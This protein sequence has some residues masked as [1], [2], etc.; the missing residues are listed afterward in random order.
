MDPTKHANKTYNLVSD[1]QTF[2]E[3]TNSFSIALDKELMYVHVP[4]DSAVRAFL[5]NGLPEYLVDEI[6]D[7]HKLIDSGSTVTNTPDLS[8]F[9]QITGEQPTNLKNWLSKYSGGFQ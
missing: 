7:T 1:R 2:R 5:E 4:Y 8:D 3:V 6:V 9:Y